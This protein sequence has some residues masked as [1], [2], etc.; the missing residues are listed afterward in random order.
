M[1][2]LGMEALVHNLAQLLLADQFVDLQREHVFQAFPF[3][4]AQVLGQRIVEDQPAQRGID[5]LGS[6][7]FAE[8][9]FNANLDRRL[10]GDLTQG[11][12][13]FGFIHGGEDPSGA[14]G[15]FVDNRQVV[16]ADNH[17]LRGRDD[18]AAVLRLQNVVMGQHQEAGF[19][20]CFKAQRYVYGHL[21]AVEVGIE[22]GTGQRMKLD[23]LAF[24]QNGLKRL[25]TQA[26]QR[27]RAVQQH[28]MI[29]DHL[30]KD[31]PH[32]GPHFFNG[33]L[34]ALDVVAVLQVHKPFHHEGLEQLQSHF[35]RQAALV[36]FQFRTDDDNAAAGVVNALAQQVLAEPALFAAKQ[37]A[38]GFQR[39]VSGTR[40]GA[41][42]AAV[43]DQGVN[44]FLQ[45]ALF[46]PDDDVRRTQ[47]EQSLQTVVPVNHPAV[48]VVQV[49]R[50]KA[51][52]VQLNQRPQIRRDHGH[53]GQ[54]H[55]FGFVMTRPERFN[56]LQPFHGAGALLAF[57]L[58]VP[59]LFGQLGDFR[60]QLFA[61]L[62]QIQLHQQVADRFG[63]H[64]GHEASLPAAGFN[65]P[66]P[67][68]VDQLKPLQA[69]FL[70]VAGIQ[71]DEVCEIQ[72]LFK[73]PR[74]NVQQHT[75]AAG[76][77]LEIPD[78]AHGSGQLNMAHAFPANLGARNLHAALVAD[79][80]LV[81]ELDPLIFSAVT[82]PVL[83]RSE[84]AFA[85]QAVPFGFQCTVVDG[86]G[87]RNFSVGP[88]EDLL[89][90]SHADLNGI[91]VGKFEQGALSPFKNHCSR[92]TVH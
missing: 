58:P 11:I 18:R 31:I 51:A 8:G 32:L 63:A 2:T 13:H 41:A 86:F 27:G 85:V 39:P 19:C 79:L 45:H 77:S 1:F 83:G 43:V 37:I 42:A 29:P 73:V 24:N 3:P 21:V 78:M 56:D 89:R 62:V 84:N 54:D 46:V 44:G 38:Q 81:F 59:F 69:G 66:I 90:G 92:F 87:L 33:T 55:P 14:L 25:N 9:A 80:V 71:H 76:D 70:G 40:H 15:V 22:C 88:R 48:Q 28:R 34:C 60:L 47:L 20:L 7:F 61:H 72:N 6:L 50:G 30:F 17:V 16:A 49:R 52:A 23:G 82:F 57:G 35:L 10:Q 75:H 67:G 12:C 91:K 53:D 26:V 5:Q 4:E 36:Q 74:G 68:V 65:F 64:L